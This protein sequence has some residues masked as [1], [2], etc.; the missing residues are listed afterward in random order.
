MRLSRLRTH[1]EV[2]LTAFSLV[3]AI[4]GCSALRR[5]GPA[6]NEPDTM[7][8]VENHGF[9]DVV[10]YAVAAGDPYRLGMVTGSS[11]AKF[12]L[13]S[14]F[15]GLGS[16][17]LLARPIAGRAYLLPA[18]SVSPGDLILVSLENSAAQSHVSVAPR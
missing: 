12:K 18:V 15:T 1:V 17:Q 6:P 14:R 16:V 5:S 3:V 4:S 10:M 7:V 9:P 13:P 2:S 11:S 8:A